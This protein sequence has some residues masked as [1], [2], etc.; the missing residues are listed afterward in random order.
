MYASFFG[1]A[2]SPFSIAPDPRYLYMSRSHQEALAHLL[3]GLRGDGGFVL[4]TGEVGTGKTTICR[5]LLDQIPASCEVAYIVN[6][7]LTA[8]E[9]LSTICNE[10]GIACP[11]EGTSIM[12]LVDRINTYL[13][14]AHA[15]GKDTVL[16][17]DEAQNLS[18]DV[19]EQ[20]R[21]L[22]NLE[23]NR[24]KLLQIIL[25]GQPELADM[26]AR[27]ELR[28]LAQR[29]VA[30][31]HLVPLPKAE[32]A[33]Y[34]R[35]RL[36]VSGARQNLIPPRLVARL[37]RLSGGVPRVLNVLCDRALLGA[38]VQGKEQVDRSTL[39]RAANEVFG[40][41]PQARR[42]TVELIAAA[43][44]LITGATVALGVYQQQRGN[45][46]TPP[47]ARSMQTEQPAAGG[48][49]AGQ[50]APEAGALLWTFDEPLSSSKAIAYATLLR[51]WGEADYGDLPCRT[52]TKSALR[53]RI[54][55]GDLNEL[56]RLDRPAILEMRDAQGRHFFAC[57][58]GLDERS[59]TFTFGTA[60]RR[61]ALDALVSQWS[62]LYIAL[63]RMPP[64]I[65]SLIRPGERGPA[66]VWLSRQLAQV[67]NAATK[68]LN[69]PVFDQTMASQVRQYQIKHGLIADGAIGSQT[70]M[71]LTA[72]TDHSAPALLRKSG[73]P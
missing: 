31:Y 6:P 23:T 5:A 12:V 22:T 51:A 7:R 1:L 71:H 67:E 54:A 36:D 16:I 59:A 37:H 25:L 13:L 62:G 45:D 61:V 64:E 63:W 11:D 34:I 65:G 66:V 69:D 53:C 30:R 14:D 44:T 38:Y 20:L 35:H 58:T 24:R 21:L 19:L 70:L 39:N 26:L 56:R 40:R 73:A 50:P 3:Y 17:I 32:V 18:V 42:R 47:T 43:F 72:A 15:N 8:V 10:F 33:R 2:E 27:P 68:P 9:L 60:T 46:G 29:I 49:S 4:L 55:R 52:N 48:T 41:R 28:Q 57:L